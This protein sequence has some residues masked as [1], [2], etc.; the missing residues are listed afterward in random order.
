[1]MQWLIFNLFLT[2]WL[3]I[4]GTSTICFSLNFLSLDLAQGEN[5]S[6]INAEKSIPNFGKIT[7]LIQTGKIF[8]SVVLNYIDMS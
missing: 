8:M 6:F 2:I 7:K 4:N 5:N 3:Y 1:M